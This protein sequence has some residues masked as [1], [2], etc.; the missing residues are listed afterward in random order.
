MRAFRNRPFDAGPYAFTRVDAP[1]QKVR[2]EGRIT[3]VHALV[4]VGVNA[5]GHCEILGLDVATA[6]DGAGFTVRL[7]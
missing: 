5:D 1:T 6:E 3:G 4:A 7:P 2:E